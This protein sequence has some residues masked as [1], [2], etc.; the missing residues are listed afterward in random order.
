MGNQIKILFFI[1]LI[2][3]IYL[4][5]IAYL[6]IGGWIWPDERYLQFFSI[7]FWKNFNIGEFIKSPP[8]IIIM[9]IINAIIFVFLKV[10]NITKNTADFAVYSII[11]LD[12]FIY[13]GRLFSIILVLG[14]IY[15][16]YKLLKKYFKIEVVL[17]TII[18]L[19]TSYSFVWSATI[20]KEDMFGFFILVIFLYYFSQYLDKKNRKYLYIASFISGFSLAV[21]QSNLIIVIDTFL[22]LIFFYKNI[23]TKSIILSIIFL[24]L[25]IIIGDPYLIFSKKD[26][27]ILKWF[28]G[29]FLVL[30]PAFQNIIFKIHPTYKTEF[31]NLIASYKFQHFHI[32]ESEEKWKEFISSIPYQSFNSIIFYLGCFLILFFTIKLCFELVKNPYILKTK[33]KYIILLF[34]IYLYLLFFLKYEIKEFRYLFPILL[35]IYL[36]P[37]ICIDKIFNFLKLRITYIL[38]IVLFFGILNLYKIYNSL[39]NQRV[40]YVRAQLYIK[41]NIPQNSNI[42]A[43]N[44]YI[45]GILFRYEINQRKI[46]KLIPY[47]E[48]KKIL[49][50]NFKIFLFTTPISLKKEDYKQQEKAF[51]EILETDFLKKI[52]Y[53]IVSKS[54]YSRFFSLNY[55]NTQHFYNY[56]S[57]NLNCVFQ[58]GGLFIY[59]H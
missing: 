39:Y 19:V 31:Y 25:G 32:G 5:R 18:F 2:F 34:H 54:L 30:F 13:T 58:E 56:L 6:G 50:D 16:S 52:D 57:E 12:I 49:N 38:V 28:I 24:F 11:N 17:I 22:I 10:M 40:P 51:K 4:L 41:N 27:I 43:D 21:K 42:L 29:M 55:P 45:P 15:Y 26:S 59:K 46:D 14:V 3:F 36:F 20:Y 1:L 44:M 33:I 47:I 53:I 7:Y 8:S 48:N 35:F 23:N 9:A 37:A